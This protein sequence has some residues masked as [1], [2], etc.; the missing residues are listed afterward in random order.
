MTFVKSG[1]FP[2]IFQWSTVFVFSII[3]YELIYG[4]S[5]AHSNFGTAM[6]WVL[7][8]PII[9]LFFVLLGRFWCAICPF[10]T[11]S[12]S[13]QK[14]VGNK[15]P[16]PIFLKKYG[17]WLIDASFILIT[18]ADHVFG[19]VESPIG[20]GILLMLIIS[21][22]IVLGAFY[23]RRTWCRYLC[24]LGGLSGN[25]SRSGCLE[26]RADS[27]KC[28]QCKYKYCY[29]GKGKVPG[30]PMF[31]LPGSM[32]SSASCNLCGYCIKTCPNN[33]VSIKPRLFSKEL[34]FIRKPKIEESF[35]AVIIMGIVLV[36]NVTMLE[37]WLSFQQ[38]IA[39]VTGTTNYNVNFTVAFVIAM[40]IPLIALY[41]T[42]WIVG[43]NNR[44]NALTNF[45]IFGYALIPLDF[46]AH[47][48]HNL[49][50]LLAEGKSVIYTA[51]AIFVPGYEGG[52]A[53]LV[54]N[55]TIQILQFAFIIL[56]LV[57]S[58][59]TTYMISINRFSGINKTFASAAPYAVLLIIVAL[60]NIQ[61]F[62]MPME[63]RM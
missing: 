40:I 56:G 21:A 58:L 54:A 43:K 6:T 10:A 27:E 37:I 33:S 57:G 48:A 1:F 5:S 52:S 19:I 11:L 18:W 30:C 4:P 7:W 14:L 62:T 46:T 16:V 20:S 53:A 42:S 55:E 8:W 31:E 29:K 15:K 28:R 12:D 34:W 25:Y 3:V 49:F 61:L 50:H 39:G 45:A 32:D 47:M 22:V 41:I 2:D 13:V 38:I 23:E 9:P 35:L 60:I 24:F 51:I 36:Q 44:E 26:L 59:Y 63:H 17:I